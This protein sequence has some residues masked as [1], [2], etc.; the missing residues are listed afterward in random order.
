MFNPRY[1]RP[2]QGVAWYTSKVTPARL[3]HPG[4]TFVTD[5]PRLETGGVLKA[6]NRDKPGINRRRT[7]LFQLLSNRKTCGCVPVLVNDQSPAA[8][9]LSLHLI[10]TTDP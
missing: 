5:Y 8:F 6:R 4:V 7:T 3:L 10:P 2:G 9:N 1:Q